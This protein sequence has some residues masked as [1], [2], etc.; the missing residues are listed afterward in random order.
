MQ[1]FDD[2]DVL[3]MAWLAMM[4]AIVIVIALVSSLLTPRRREVLPKPQPRAVVG[5]TRWYRVTTARLND[6]RPNGG[7][8]GD[9]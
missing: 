4:F 7:T 3:A 9:I 1:T 5:H 2:L 6:H 8:R